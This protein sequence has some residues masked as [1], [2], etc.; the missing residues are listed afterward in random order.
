MIITQ[1]SKYDID[2]V[3]I[4]GRLLM[5]DVDEA[6]DSLK[7]VIEEG[8]GKLILDL[9]QLSFIDSSGCGVLISALKGIRGR[10]GRIALCNLT[11]NVRTLLELT[12]VI[13]L[14]EVFQSTEAAI[15]AFTKNP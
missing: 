14:F 13:E 3:E 12:R 11:R 1:Q 6:K 2:V 4:S 9:S 15:A 10:S 5:A 7:A 8:N